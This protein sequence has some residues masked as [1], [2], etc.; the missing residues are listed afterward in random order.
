[1]SAMKPWQRTNQRTLVNCPIFDVK[2]TDSV[3]PQ[4]GKLHH[5]YFIDSADWVNIVPITTDNEVVLIRQFRHGCQDMTL[6][7]PGGMVDAGELPEVA[8]ARECLEE[9]G[10][11]ATKIQ[12]LGV[13]NPNPALFD[14]KLHT[15]MARDVVAVSEINNSSTEHTEVV[16]VPLDELQGML[17]CGDIDHAL[18]VAT[19]WRMLYWHVAGLAAGNGGVTVEC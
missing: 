2:E 11:Q 14:N 17:M 10:Y 3:S 16:L 1:M 5:F 19:L 15:Y 6:E 9:T 13:L 7:I 8:A 4:T 18:V 12:S